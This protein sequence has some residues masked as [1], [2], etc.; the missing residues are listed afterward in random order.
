MCHV[1]SS[2]AGKSAKKKSFPIHF[3]KLHLYDTEETLENKISAPDLSLPSNMDTT[4]F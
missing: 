1:F 4:T 3:S 2:N